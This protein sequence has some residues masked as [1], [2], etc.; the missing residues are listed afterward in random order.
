MLF[1]HAAAAY[2]LYQ[3]R[4]LSKSG[5]WRYHARPLFAAMQAGISVTDIERNDQAKR[6]RPGVN[7]AF[8][9]KRPPHFCTGLWAPQI[10]LLHLKVGRGRDA[11]W[12]SR[13]SAEL[14]QR[15]ILSSRGFCKLASSVFYSSGW[16]FFKSAYANHV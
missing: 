2:R 9:K 11:L 14:W 13:L 10:R 4:I 15:D 8:R 7:Q 1:P 5:R 12:A 6:K 3:D 16:T